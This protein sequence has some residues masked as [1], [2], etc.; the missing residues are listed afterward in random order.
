MV[1][2]P[3]KRW[4]TAA[5][6]AVAVLSGLAIRCALAAHVSGD[7]RV[8]LLPWY[9]FARAHGLGSLGIPFTN[10]PPYYTYVLLGLTRLEGL[11]SPLTL[12]KAVSAIFELGCA[13]MAARIASLARGGRW[14]GALAFAGVWL[15]PT[16]LLNGPYWAQ[17]DSLWTFFILVS[18]RLFMQARNGIPAFALA[19]AVKLQCIFF[20]PFMLGRIVGRRALWPWLAVVPVVYLVVALPVLI[21]GRPLGS[22][23]SIYL[24][25]ANT[26]HL[27]SLN[28]ASVWIFGPV[29]ETLGTVIGLISATLAGLFVAVMTAR[30]PD[31]DHEGL[32]VAACASLLIM[33]FLLPKMHD[34]YFYAFEIAS[35]V[36][37]CANPR[38]VA[39]AVIAQANGVLSYMMFDARLPLETLAPAAICNAGMAI[40]L[41]E[42]MLRPRPGRRMPRAA[43]AAFLGAAVL[44]LGILATW[45]RHGAL[46]AYPLF[47]T[48][49]CLFGVNLLWSTRRE[50][51]T[52]TS[53]AAPVVARTHG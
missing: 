49:F 16:V 15:A 38:Y 29:D 27:L 34:R 47:A 5:V 44:M 45:P 13:V 31:G 6:V 40:L 3:M 43:L 19:F 4:A 12:I 1:D 36:L 30:I 21:A 22:V 2:A 7:A 24:D 41:I 18:L 28:A 9:A 53:A 33:P 42:Q 14:A 46:R 48:A 10:Y 52:P 39:L 50:G 20:G 25:Q 37:A 51:P 35:I 17:A 32:M 23:L 11:A 8:Y 26:Y